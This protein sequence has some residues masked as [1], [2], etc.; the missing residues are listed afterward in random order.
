MGNCILLITSREKGKG[1][2]RR[3]GEEG[4]GGEKEKK[5][6]IAKQLQQRKRGEKGRRRCVA[7]ETSPGTIANPRVPL[8]GGG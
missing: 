6:K 2:E 8:K 1:R 3:R 4:G 5:K 7:R